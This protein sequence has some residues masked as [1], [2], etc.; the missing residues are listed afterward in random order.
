MNYSSIIRR[1]ERWPGSGATN[2]T[3][4]LGRVNSRNRLKLIQ[5]SL[6]RPPLGASSAEPWRD[7]HYRNRTRKKA[8]LMILGSPTDHDRRL[9]VVDRER[10]ADEE[11]K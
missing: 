5:R 7:V 4:Q 11:E 3:E 8:R 10:E 6:P 9:T 1:M 2:D